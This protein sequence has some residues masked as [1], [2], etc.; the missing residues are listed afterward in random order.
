M[1]NLFKQKTAT[2]FNKKYQ[3]IHAKFVRELANYSDYIVTDINEATETFEAISQKIAA[4]DFDQ[5]AVEITPSNAVKFIIK[6]DDQLLISIIKPFGTVEDLGNEDVIFN[7]Y[8]DRELLISDISNI[9]ALAK[10]IK[11]FIDM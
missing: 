11:D 3:Q 7:F 10:G 5:I 2:V 1:F 8:K 9:D 4:L 6:L